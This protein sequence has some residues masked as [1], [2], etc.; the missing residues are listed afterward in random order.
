MEDWN[1]IKLVKRKSHYGINERK[2]LDF[3]FQ[4]KKA[5]NKL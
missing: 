5:G 3:S 4:I 2:F 1:N